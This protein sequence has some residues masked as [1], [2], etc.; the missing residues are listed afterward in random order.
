MI[1]LRQPT[2]PAA[3]AARTVTELFPIIRGM[4]ADQAVV[5]DATPAW[6]KLVAQDTNATPTLS[7]AMPA[8]VTDAAVVDMVP[9]EG[10]VMVKLGGVVSVLPPEPGPVVLTVC[11]VTMTDFETRLP[12]E[13]AVTTIVLAPTASAT[14]AML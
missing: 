7:L 2:L 8:M 10:E 4:A 12:P 14:L 6:P 9:D 11:R 3:S 5:P 1:T 13:E